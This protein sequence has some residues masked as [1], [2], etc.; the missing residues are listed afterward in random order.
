MNS[1][2]SICEKKIERNFDFYWKRPMTRFEKVRSL[3]DDKKKE[4][5]NVSNQNSNNSPQSSTNARIC[6]CGIIIYSNRNRLCIFFCLS[7]FG[8]ESIDFV[9]AVCVLECALAQTNEQVI[10]VSS[11]PSSVDCSLYRR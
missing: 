2:S 10:F 7:Y 1:N 6:F 3:A 4:N 5:G 9:W 8:R 11:L